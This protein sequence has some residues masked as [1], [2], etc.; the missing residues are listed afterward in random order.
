MNPA[1]AAYLVS[2]ALHTRKTNFTTRE[3]AALSIVA[4]ALSVWNQTFLLMNVAAESIELLKKGKK[5][6]KPHESRAR[7]AFQCVGREE[8]ECLNPTTTFSLPWP[9]ITQAAEGK[10][11]WKVC[12]G[13][14]ADRRQTTCQVSHSCFVGQLICSSRLHESLC[15]PAMI[16]EQ[17]CIYKWMV[18]V[19]NVIV[20]RLAYC[21]ELH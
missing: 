9:F 7:L 10:G 1:A 21:S 14:S 4:A 13:N 16:S 3:T 12:S 18:I 15:L 6:E 5:K 8:E 11:N 2:I 20:K 17:S 19:K